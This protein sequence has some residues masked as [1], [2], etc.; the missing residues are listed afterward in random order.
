MRGNNITK[1]LT[2]L[3]V[4]AGLA[5]LGSPAVYAGPGGGTL[6]GTD[7][8]SMNLV[9]IDP[10]TGLNLT[11][12]S[13]GDDLQALAVRPTDGKVFAGSGRG[14]N[15]DQAF[16]Y[17]IVPGTPPVVP[18]VVTPLS[19][20]G[21]GADA[22]TGM[23]FD[24]SASPVLFAT[25]D[26]DDDGGGDTLATIDTVTGGAI[27]TS[28]LLENG[29]AVDGFQAIAFASDG[30]LWGTQVV[31]SGAFFDT[32]LYTID[33]SNG[34]ATIHSAITD[35]GSGLSPDG[36]ITGLQF[37]CG[38]TLYAGTAFDNFFI[39]DGGNLG[40]LGPLDIPG[41][42]VYDALIGGPAVFTFGDSVGA[43]AFADSCAPP[44]PTTLEV[45]VNLDLN[46]GMPIRCDQTNRDLTAAVLSSDGSVTPA[47]DATTINADTVRFGRDGSETLAS[48]THQQ[49]GSA[50]R[51]EQDANGDGLTDL[52]F[53]F[54]L[55]DTGFSCAD[56]T[57]GNSALIP[58]TLSGQL[59]GGEEFEGTGQFEMR[60]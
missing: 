49:N 10:V 35:S 58:A 45:V 4:M 16:V 20:A 5:V 52:V 37:D 13:V 42:A 57:S 7:G 43:L 9:T 36:G 23:D 32:Y 17:T 48:E 55:G 56:I 14:S 47:F 1:H 26:T 41:N 3:A 12:G 44:P 29:F 50:T 59:A 21:A 6:Y 2:N 24:N 54:R 15:P 30:T 34:S 53:H 51:H 19:F 27:T 22:I 33:P 60:K 11:S 39:G 28:P 40:T 46:P 31:D 25:L 8:A 18:H 38:G